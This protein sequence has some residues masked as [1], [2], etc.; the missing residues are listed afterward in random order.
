MPSANRSGR[1][2]TIAARAR[3]SG[4]ESCA[5]MAL[6]GQL[7]ESFLRE[8]YSASTAVPSHHTFSRWFCSLDPSSSGPC[9]AKFMQRFAESCQGVVAIDGK[10]LR[11]SLTS[12]C[13]PLG[14]HLPRAWGCEQRLCALGQLAVDGKSNEITAA[15]RRCSSDLCS[16]A[17]TSSPPMRSTASALIAAAGHWPVRR[18][19]S[20]LQEL[21]QRPAYPRAH[22][23][24]RSRHAAHRRLR[25]GQ[26]LW[27]DRAAPGQRER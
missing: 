20:A 21:R 13:L 19:R 17:T 4:G 15:P 23:P 12:S 8:F 27:P 16:R 9:F 11:V 22:L 2:L 6:F 24:R 1:S 7:K 14:A 25:Y 18:S 3:R 26:R 10:T 5:D